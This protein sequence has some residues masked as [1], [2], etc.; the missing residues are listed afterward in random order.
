MQIDEDF[1]KLI[2]TLG[3]DIVNKMNTNWCRINN[4]YERNFDIFCY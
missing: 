1:M 4:D 3:L 2:K